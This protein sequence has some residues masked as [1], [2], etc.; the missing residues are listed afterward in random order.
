MGA[1]IIPTSAVRIDVRESL[2]HFVVCEFPPWLEVRFETLAEI[3]DCVGRSTPRARGVLT[4]TLARRV[5]A[6][7][8]LAA[9]ILTAE[10]RFQQQT[11]VC[12][13]LVIAVQVQRTCRLQ[14]AFDLDQPFNHERQVSG[15]RIVPRV[16][17]GVDEPP[18]TGADRLQF[19]PEL[20]RD[21]DREAPDILEL[22]RPS[23]LV[24]VINA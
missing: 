14:Y 15:K 5:L 9:E 17:A 12:V 8:Y 7:D 4:A 19:L 3:E 1:V 18:C 20:L 21:A 22:R 2:C 23:G 10:Q 13:G 6:P 24:G 16:A 11:Q